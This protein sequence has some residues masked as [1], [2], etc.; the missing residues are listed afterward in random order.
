[1][2]ICLN[3]VQS[4]CMYFTC[5]TVA[6]PMLPIGGAMLPIGGA[7]YPPMPPMASHGPRHCPSVAL[8]PRPRPSQPSSMPHKLTCP[9]TC[10]SLLLFP[11]AQNSGCS[12]SWDGV[13][14]EASYEWDE[15]FILFKKSSSSSLQCIG[16]QYLNNLA[17]KQ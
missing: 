17:K 16:S 2:G 12:Y 3:K 7:M 6:S 8:S 5:I 9:P 10:C 11:S 4:S 14:W 13:S 15:T 1:M